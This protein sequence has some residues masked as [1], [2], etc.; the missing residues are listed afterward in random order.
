MAHKPATRRVSVV[1]CPSGRAAGVLSSS[2]VG[3]GAAGNR[4]P[5]KGGPAAASSGAGRVES[6]V[7]P[8]GEAARGPMIGSV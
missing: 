3:R 2:F 8:S 6:A 4:P 5:V 1:T 7:G